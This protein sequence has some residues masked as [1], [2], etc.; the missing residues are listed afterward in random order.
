MDVFHGDSMIYVTLMP[1]FQLFIEPSLLFI[2]DNFIDKR[3]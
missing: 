1:I 3:S 2:G